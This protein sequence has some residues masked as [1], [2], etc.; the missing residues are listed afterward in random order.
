MIRH[1]PIV[2]SLPFFFVTEHHY[3]VLDLFSS[4]KYKKNEDGCTQPNLRPTTSLPTCFADFERL[5]PDSD[6]VVLCLRLK[7]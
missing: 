7:R 1:Q 6:L 3:I 4:A 5:W 2:A